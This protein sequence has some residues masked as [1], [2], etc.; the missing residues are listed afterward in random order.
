MAIN[1]PLF[2]DDPSYNPAQDIEVTQNEW[3]KSVYPDA[4]V[5]LMKST[6]RMETNHLV[7]QVKEEH[8]DRQIIENAGLLGNIG[9]GLTAGL[10]D[11]VNWVAMGGAMKAAK[12]VGLATRPLA[13]GA[14]GATEN[15][16]ALTAAEPFLQA[17]QA[18]RTTEEFQR[19]LVGGAVFGSILG[20]VVGSVSS[21]RTAVNRRLLGADSAEDAIDPNSY[22]QWLADNPSDQQTLDDLLEG[23][24]GF[25]IFG[26]DR[27]QISG[28]LLKATKEIN[29]GLARVLGTGRNN[30]LSRMLVRMLFLNP[31]MNLARSQSQFAR[32]ALDIML[33]P[34]IVRTD[35]LN[36][37]SVEAVMGIAEIAALRVRHAM[38]E[39]F[40][41]Y[42]QGGGALSSDQIMEI[43]GRAAVR[44]DVVNQ[45][46]LPDY[47]ISPTDGTLVEVNPFEALD[48]AGVKVVEKIAKTN[49]KFFDAF[50]KTAIA[51]GAFTEQDFVDPD[52]LAN[53]LTRRYLKDKIK[54]FDPQFKESVK[55]GLAEKKRLEL[56]ELE[57]ERDGRTTDLNNLVARLGRM[58]D[59]DPDRAALTWDRDQLVREIEEYETAISLLGDESQWDYVADLVQQNITDDISDGPT[60][61]MSNSLKRRVLDIDDRFLAGF[62]ETNVSNIQAH[63]I[64]TLLPK[65]IMSGELDKSMDGFQVSRKLQRRLTATT[66][67]LEEL[68]SDPNNLNLDKISEVRLDL[69]LLLDD[70]AHLRL[71]THLR[72]QLDVERLGFSSMQEA[73]VRVNDLVTALKTTKRELSDKARRVEVHDLEITRATSALSAAQG[74]NLG[75][76]V[77]QNLQDT[78]DTL[79]Q[80]RSD[81]KNDIKMLRLEGNDT[82]DSLGNISEQMI[83]GKGSASERL[84]GNTAT[85][86]QEL[87]FGANYLSMG[88]A[89]TEEQKLVRLM[90]LKNSVV[91]RVSN[92][93]REAYEINLHDEQMLRRIQEDY[94]RLRNNVDVEYQSQRI[95]FKRKKRET[96]KLLKQEARDLEDMRVIFKRFH[97]TDGV[98]NEGLGRIGKTI[99]DVNYVRLGG[100]FLLSSAPDPAMIIAQVGLPTFI[101]SMARYMNPFFRERLSEDMGD[102]VFAAE[103]VLGGERNSRIAGLSDLDPARA[104]FLERGMHNSSR[105]FSRALM[106]NRWNGMMKDISSSAIQHKLI[107]IGNK[108]RAGKRLSRSDKAFIE[109]LGLDDDRLKR[110]AQLQEEFGEN[111]TTLLGGQYHIARTRRWGKTGSIDSRVALED[112]LAFE[113]AVFQRVQQTIVTPGAGQIPRWMTSSEMGRII[114]QFGSFTM[115]ATNQVLVP[116]VQ[117]GAMMGD[118]NQVAMFVGASTLGAMGYWARQSLNGKNPFEDEVKK[119]KSGRVIARVPWWKK[120]IMEGI[121]RGGTMGWLTQGNA[122]ME[123]MTGVGASTALGAGQLSRMQTR[124]KVDILAGPTAGF[125]NDLGTLMGS[126]AAK[127]VEGKPF[128][129]GAYNAGR[130]ML[131]GQNLTQTR[132]ALDVAPTLYEQR[133]G[134]YGNPT[135]PETF[136]PVQQRLRNFL[137]GL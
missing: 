18:T 31:E 22:R 106:L 19:D 66:K 23:S 39:A 55:L 115:A 129:E 50:R 38:D 83:Y 67:K 42:R 114:S 91:N 97:K 44:G 136:V 53:Y 65:L 105:L 116:M 59:D 15:V 124:S 3:I 102:W 134:G 82:R 47:V 86:R 92:S 16:L 103:A 34:A 84:G 78:L 28:I 81:L 10:V 71:S 1:K 2:V 111:S 35:T 132:L 49:R 72:L 14:V 21:G 52:K 5:R 69:E 60:G 45:N 17:A 131:L 7:N 41:D 133:D 109:G 119:D 27:E 8:A 122:M 104:T 30:F 100:G 130:R 79:K 51:V 80:N 12:A 56:P 107:K 4:F 63:Q 43:A 87:R 135:Y 118:F 58:A 70:A 127:L 6:S 33:K 76:T 99:R 137:Q 128:T 90:M 57:S 73:Q 68:Q 89:I 96:E 24:E 37:Q 77:I 40:A 88:G 29:P 9:S 74:R 32:G 117:K 75:R 11:P 48:E 25:S 108:K 62:V 94:A 123:R 112:R 101:R 61:L 113:R 64:R 125:I 46:T 20:G 121:D 36:R 93:R 110:I 13:V 26:E 54:A 126:T 85:R 95:T 120:S 98:G